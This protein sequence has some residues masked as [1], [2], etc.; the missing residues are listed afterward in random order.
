M[1]RSGL[2]HTEVKDEVRDGLDDWCDDTES[3]LHDL[4]TE[5]AT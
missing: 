1:I 5:E 4:A 3:Y 2:A